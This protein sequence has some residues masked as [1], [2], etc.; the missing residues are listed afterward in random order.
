MLVG[1]NR[2]WF[3][4]TAAEGMEP[5]VAAGWDEVRGDST[6]NDL[7]TQHFPFP[8]LPGTT[9]NGQGIRRIDTVDSSISKI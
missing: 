1:I 3:T 7:I 4:A 6:I 8:P 9:R 2:E 5:I